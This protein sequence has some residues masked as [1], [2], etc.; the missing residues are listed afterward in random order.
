MPQMT[1][2]QAMQFGFSRH[3]AGDFAEAESVYRQVLSRFPDFAPA[4]HLL[5][6]ILAQRGQSAEGIELIRRAIEREPATPDFRNTL[7]AFLLSSGKIQEAIESCRAAIQIK[8]DYAEVHQTLGNALCQAG[9]VAEARLAYEEALRLQPNLAGSCCNLATLHSQAGEL[10]DA[11]HLMT[12]VIELLPNWAAGYDNLASVLHQAGRPREAIAMARKAVE[13]APKVPEARSKLLF[14]LGFDPAAD[15]KQILEEH[16]EW[17][18]LFGG[19]RKTINDF[20]SLDRSPDR[21]LRVGYFSPDFREHSV[22][23]FFLGLLAH[24]DRTRVESYCY[25][26]SVAAD[27]MTGK[28]RQAAHQWRDAIRL[29]D[30]AL[31]DQI[32][33]D[34]I[35]IFVDLAGNTYGGRPV[36]F[37]NQPAPIQ[38]SYLGYSQTTGLRTIAYRLTDALVDPPT[39]DAI[40]SEQL[41]RLPHAFATFSPPDDAPPTARV[42]GPF[43]FGSFCSLAKMSDDFIATASRILNELPDSRL[44]LVAVGLADPAIASQLAARFT[45]HHID[46]AR[47]EMIGYLPLAAYLKLHQ[48]VDLILDSFPVT[49]HTTVCQGLWMGVPSVCLEGKYYPQRLAASVMRHVG[50]TEFVASS[51]DE[52]VQIARRFAGDANHRASLRESLRRRMSESVLLDHA[53]IAAAMEAEY[54]SIWHALLRGQ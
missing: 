15:A 46:A 19:P 24:H 31:I 47:L 34:Q 39:S 20:K 38:V 51:T 12:R 42:D 43:T 8:P 14:L 33:T 7:A 52:Y 40:F 32:R 5:G 9:R 49:G 37:A 41:I 22:A 4:L 48:R 3:Q 27:A 35:D 36:I 21:P 18:R 29:S 23:S 13:L 11:I 10:A 44:I 16:R 28:L 17:D 30:D 54:R 50:L 6:I 1:L 26:N 2:E 25:S 53:A 45:A